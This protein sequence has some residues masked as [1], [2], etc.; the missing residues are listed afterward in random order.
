[1]KKVLV[2][3]LLAMTA[4]CAQLQAGAGGSA[5]QQFSYPQNGG[6]NGAF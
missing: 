2:V 5:P 1:M 4:A 3:L 6:V